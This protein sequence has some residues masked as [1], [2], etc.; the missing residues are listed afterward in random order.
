[1]IDHVLISCVGL[2]KNRPSDRQ[3]QPNITYAVVQNLCTVSPNARILRLEKDFCEGG[4]AAVQH[5]T[6]FDRESGILCRVSQ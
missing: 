3:L 6:L 4:D 2:V 5:K 1:M